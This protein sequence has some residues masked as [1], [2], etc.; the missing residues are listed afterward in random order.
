MN[1]PAPMLAYKQSTPC[2]IGL[3]FSNWGYTNKKEVDYPQYIRK[4]FQFSDDLH[5]SP[6]RNVKLRRTE[7]MPSFFTG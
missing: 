5:F 4:Y 7:K 6:K 3:Q 2:K 1:P